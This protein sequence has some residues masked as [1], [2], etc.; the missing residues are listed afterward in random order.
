MKRDRSF[1]RSWAILAVTAAAASLAVV[2]ASLGQA[3][4]GFAFTRYAGQNR[5]D[6]ASQIAKDT[7]TT[8]DTVVIASGEV[9]PDALAASYVAGVLGSP[10]LLVQRNALPQETSDALTALK[11]TKAIIVGGSAA[12][13]PSVETALQGKKITT[14]RLQGTNRYDTAKN[15]AES[16]GKKSAAIVVSGEGFAD[17]LAAGPAAYAGGLPVVLTAASSLSPEAQAALGD[18][19]VKTALVVGGTSAVS[20]ATEDQIAGMGIT[21]TRLSG[22]NRAGTAAAVGDYEVANLGFSTATVDLANGGNFPDALAGSA[23][24]GKTKS[25]LMLTLDPNT[26]D[27]NAKSWLNKHADTLKSGKIDGGTSAVSAQAEAEATQSSTAPTSTTSSTTGSSTTSTSLLGSTPT[28]VPGPPV[29]NTVSVS[30]NPVSSTITLTYSEQINCATVAANGTDYTVTVTPP[31]G[32]GRSAATV[33]VSAQASCSSGGNTQP[34][35]TVALTGPG[36]GAATGTINA[37]DTV[38]VTAKQGT[39]GDT[40]KDTD[41]PTPSSEAVG[42]T[43]STVVASGGPKLIA[44]SAGNGSTTIVLTYDQNL[45]PSTCS[46]AAATLAAD[47][48]IA[49]NGGTGTS[50]AGASC[51]PGSSTMTLTGVAALASTNTVTVTYS[52]AGG[53]VQNVTGATEVN[54]DSISFTVA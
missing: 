14:S 43:K 54:G 36:N 2:N 1:R 50:P 9:F 33:A 10:V 37:G 19:G 48:K 6:T 15:I 18:L 28:T 23:H 42:D 7:F 31:S 4:T 46:K 32:S 25:A 35:S 34:S 5:Y 24:G 44:A 21:V 40:V 47:Y 12:V 26:L 3:A 30:A 53:D 13:D 49:V 22:T 39:D 41:K 38:T 51:T 27:T 20:K 29:L 45:S 8:A 11:T 16:A 17:A 52:S